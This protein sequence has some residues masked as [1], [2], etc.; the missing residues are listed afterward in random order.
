MFRRELDRLDLS[1]AHADRTFGREQPRLAMLHYPPWIEGQ[2][3]TPVVDRLKKARA[4]VVV[5]G[6]LHGEDHALA[7]RGWRDGMF[8]VFV[9]ADAVGFTPVLLP[10]PTDE[11]A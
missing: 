8:Y 3:P 1:T 2:S 10:Q 6:H 5:Y 11:L 9:A 4:R 7:V